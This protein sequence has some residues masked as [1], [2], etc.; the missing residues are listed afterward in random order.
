MENVE[1]EIQGDTLILRVDLTKECGFTGGGKSVRI[2]SSEGNVQLWVDGKPHPDK[3]RFNLNVFRSLK[4]EEQ[5]AAE[6]HRRS[7]AFF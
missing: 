6:E 4:P 5:K 2:G 3:I 7:G 1:L